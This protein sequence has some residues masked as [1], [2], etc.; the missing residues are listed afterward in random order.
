[1]PKG[2]M[3]FERP[4]LFRDRVSELNRHSNMSW[5]RADSKRS[6]NW[7]YFSITDPSHGDCSRG[8]VVT[9]LNKV[10]DDI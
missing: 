2:S 8:K 7:D 4:E 10:V 3:T 1:M 5:P 6:P 9:H